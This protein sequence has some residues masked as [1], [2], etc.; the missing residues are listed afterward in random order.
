[1][2]WFL[3]Y[4]ISVSW[5]LFLRSL[6]AILKFDV[7]ANYSLLQVDLLKHGLP[8]PSS[9]I[10]SH[11]QNSNVASEKE[12]KEKTSTSE[13]YMATPIFVHAKWVETF[14][15]LSHFFNKTQNVV[16]NLIRIRSV[17]KL[18]N[19][20]LSHERTSYNAQPSQRNTIDCRLHVPANSK[21]P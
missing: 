10:S 5:H 15:L 20:Y 18:R 9:P 6:L 17:F 13:E 7:V 16:D 3:L 19:Y 11:A 21:K 2:S 14:K 8:D 12:Y 4:V 1:M